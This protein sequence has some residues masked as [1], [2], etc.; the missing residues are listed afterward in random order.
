M[1]VAARDAA[2]AALQV[3]RAMIAAAEAP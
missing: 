1:D 3:A 2:L